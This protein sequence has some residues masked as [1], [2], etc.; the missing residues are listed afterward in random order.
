MVVMLAMFA[1]LTACGTAPTRKEAASTQLHVH[2]NASEQTNPD[3]DDRA[4]PIMVRV[5]E[6]KSPTAFEDTDFFTLQNDG[7]AAIGDDA[8]AMDEFILRPGESRDIQRKINPDTTAIGVLAGYR[9][10]G[11]SVWRTVYRVPA[12]DM[13]VE[14]SKWYQRKRRPKKVSLTVRLD[15]RVVSISRSRD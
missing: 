6:L 10:L 4:S 7:R 14:T 3:A 15:R 2:V 8:V 9:V 12:A 5:Y 11:K 1:F 13:Q